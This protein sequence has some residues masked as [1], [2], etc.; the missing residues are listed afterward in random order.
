MWKA[1]V[2]C[3]QD[4][5]QNGMSDEQIDITLIRRFFIDNAWL[6]VLNAYEKL[7]KPWLC[8][9]CAIIDQLK[10]NSNQSNSCLDWHNFSNQEFEDA[11]MRM[12]DGRGTY[13]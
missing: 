2:E 7:K 9:L 12:K 3:N 5:L 4:K 11:I 1:N 13:Y 10:K 8:S 6:A